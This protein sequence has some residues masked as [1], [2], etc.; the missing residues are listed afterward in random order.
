LQGYFEVLGK[1]P[2]LIYATRDQEKKPSQAF[3]TLFLQETIQRG[4]LMPSLVVSYSHQDVDIDRTIEA[5]N[6]VL[7]VYS[8]ALEDG[9]EKYLDGRPVKPVFRRFN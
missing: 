6:E 4:L 2:N 5:I 9:V 1:N 3:R 7:G 8:K